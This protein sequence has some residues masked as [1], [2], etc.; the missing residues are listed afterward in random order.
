MLDILSALYR[1]DPL[2]HQ[3]ICC[4]DDPRTIEERQVATQLRAVNEEAAEKLKRGIC[5][6]ADTQAEQSFYT[7]V[8]FGAQLMIQLLEELP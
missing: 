2:S 5:V 1:D 4:L 8:R 6:L 7:G 3:A